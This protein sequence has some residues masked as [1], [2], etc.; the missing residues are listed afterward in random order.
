MDREVKQRG[1]SIIELLIIIAIISIIMGVAYNWIINLVA[2]QRLKNAADML[3]NDL[4]K[5][6]TMSVSGRYMWGVYLSPGENCYLIFEDRDASCNITGTV[7]AS[8]NYS[9]TADVVSRV[10]LP[11]GVVVDTG[12]SVVFDRK[13]YPRNDGCGVGPVTITLRSTVTGSRRSI[14]ITSFGRIRYEVE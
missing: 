1:F 10:D 3:M 11:P 8:C 6:K 13:G 12:S 4:S 14:Y 7:N 9:G 2:N 5:A